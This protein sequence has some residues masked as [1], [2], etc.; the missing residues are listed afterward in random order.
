MFHL[1]ITKFIT[2]TVSISS[3]KKLSKVCRVLWNCTGTSQVALFV[4]I[5]EGTGE[6]FVSDIGPDALA[7]RWVVPEDV[8]AMLVSSVKW[9]PRSS[10]AFW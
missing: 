6:E 5:A 7:K 2:C 3:N 9:Y 10:S 1:Y 8:I 4:S